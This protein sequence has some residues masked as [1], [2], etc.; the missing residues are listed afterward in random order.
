MLARVRLNSRLLPFRSRSGRR[1]ISGTSSPS[2]PS[3]VSSR[4]GCG[5]SDYGHVV[6]VCPIRGGWGVQRPDAN[7]DIPQRPDGPAV[8]VGAAPDP[9][10]L[11]RAAPEDID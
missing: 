7:T 9:G 11:R 3:I 8:A 10:V 1:R 6:T 4:S 2:E 5:A